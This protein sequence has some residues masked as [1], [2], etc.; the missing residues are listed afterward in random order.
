[1]F[2]GEEAF[3]ELHLVDERHVLWFSDVFSLCPVRFHVEG[4]QSPFKLTLPRRAH[5]NFGGVG[6]QK[7]FPKKRLVSFWSLAEE[8]EVGRA[9]PYLILGPLLFR[10][11]PPVARLLLL[12]SISAPC[13]SMSTMLCFAMSLGEEAAKC[14]SRCGSEGCPYL[15]PRGLQIQGL[16]TSSSRH[17]EG[18][19]QAWKTVTTL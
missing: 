19:A 8:M 4:T 12:R 2:S 5:G 16:V 9:H 17:P 18:R 11:H 13:L 3:C 1:M 10:P 15:C 6:G 14:C 7:C